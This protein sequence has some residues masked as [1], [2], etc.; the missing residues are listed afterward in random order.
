[1]SQESHIQTGIRSWLEN[2]SI[3]NLFQGFIGA[4]K[5]RR[6]H[7]K[8]EFSLEKGMKILDIGCGTGV[9][10]DFIDDSILYYGCDLESKYINHCQEKFKDSKNKSFYLEKVGEVERPEWYN[11]F[12]YINA[13]G[14]LHHLDDDDCGKLLQISYKYLKKGGKLVTVDG[15]LHD[16]QSKAAA[17]F[18]SKDRGQNIKSP[19]GYINLGKTYFEK[20]SGHIDDNYSWIMPYS[21]FIMTMER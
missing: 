15:T 2:P 13:H 21:V 16:A 20:V 1:M 12:D 8:K 19:K 17:W 10:A 4:N 11:S 18:V 14:L 6:L 3:Y 9:F 5:H 7:F